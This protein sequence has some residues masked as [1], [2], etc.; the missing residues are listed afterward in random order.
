MSVPYEVL[1][2]EETQHFI[3]KTVRFPEVETP[4]RLAFTH[5]GHYIGN[6]EFANRLIQEYGL[7]QIQPAHPSH[8]ICSIGF[9]EKER[10][11]Y[12]WSH[13]A[14]C[15]FGVGSEV[16]QGDCAYKPKPDIIEWLKA[17]IDWY[18]NIMEAKAFTFTRETF[19]MTVTCKSGLTITDQF[20]LED[21]GRGEWKAQ[22]EQDSKIMAQDFAK[23]VSSARI[24][25]FQ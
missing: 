17:K 18:I 22:T 20:K 13:R 24:A 5:E 23:S 15:S 12:G 10:K 4:S 14:M 11:W 19:T 2:E 9:N 1:S 3:I 16:K 8:S 25:R 6:H 21:C 7:S